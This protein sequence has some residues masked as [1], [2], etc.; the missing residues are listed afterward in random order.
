MQTNKPHNVVLV[1]DD[2]NMSDALWCYY[3][4]EDR[5]EL[6]LTKVQGEEELTRI[7]FSCTIPDDEKEEYNNNGDNWYTFDFTKD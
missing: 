3:S 4:Y 7:S 1:T 2:Q 5:T 6:Y